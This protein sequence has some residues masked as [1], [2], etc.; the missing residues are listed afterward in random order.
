MAD[1]QDTQTR[2]ANTFLEFIIAG[3][4]DAAVERKMTQLKGLVVPPGRK[5]PVAV[6]VIIVPELMDIETAEPWEKKE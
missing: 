4:A 3:M 1:N 6:R 2:R 5:T